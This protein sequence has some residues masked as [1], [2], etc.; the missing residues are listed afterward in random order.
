MEAEVLEKE[1]IAITTMPT[2]DFFVKISYQ[3]PEI[4]FETLPCAGKQHAE[5]QAVI[6][7]ARISGHL[8]GAFE[9]AVN[10]IPSI[11]QEYI[12]KS[13]VDFLLHVDLSTPH[14]SG[15]VHR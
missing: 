6:L 13:G 8:L 9:D 1:E 11:V 5:L 3:R 15:V 4:N 12:Q 2:V 10:N 7:E 14:F